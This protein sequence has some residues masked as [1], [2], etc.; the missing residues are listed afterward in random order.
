MNNVA[1][2][3]NAHQAEC[4]ATPVWVTN[5]GLKCNEAEV[6]FTELRENVLALSKVAEETSINIPEEARRRQTARA[7]QIS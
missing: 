5:Y 2:H 1:K 6:S 7:C 3:F 4:C